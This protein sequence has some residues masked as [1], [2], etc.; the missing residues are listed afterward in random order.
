MIGLRFV[1]GSPPIWPALVER[2][3]T[4]L[5]VTLQG[6]N[7]IED[8]DG[9]RWAILPT[10]LAC[11]AR[12]WAPWKGVRQNVSLGNLQKISK[13]LGITISELFKT[14]EKRAETSRKDAVKRTGSRQPTAFR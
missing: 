6:H 9:A 7:L 4:L 12:T 14:V 2:D 10:L 3:L 8:R 5:A 1:R 13:A 11:T